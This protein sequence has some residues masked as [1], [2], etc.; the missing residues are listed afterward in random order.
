MPDVLTD[1]SRASL[2]R[3]VKANL[4]DFLKLMGRSPAA[5][6]VEDGPLISWH[7]ALPHPWF[8][9]VLASRTA[10]HDAECLIAGRLAY[11]QERGVASVSW[12]LEPH[13]EATDWQ[14]HLLRAG[15]RVDDHTPGMAVDLSKLRAPAQK[16]HG[17]EVVPVQ[18]DAALHAWLPPFLAG[19][20]LPTTLL[21]SLVELFTGLGFGLPLRQY[22]GY[23]DGEP[24]ATSSLYLGAGVAGI[25]NVATRAEARGGGI[26]TE[27]TVAPLRDAQEFG[28]K[29]GILQS[30][31][32]GFSLYLRLGFEQVCVMNHYIWQA[33]G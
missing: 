17:L 24:V 20:G 4:Y 15:F 28:Y 19:Y 12:W 21:E 10:P 5:A 6:V 25:Y 1:F 13:V 27:L 11:F 32:K 31:K 7:T 16:R 2:E 33:G 22:L 26:G 14:P 18:D 3:S 29:V 23:L 9:G 30:S 8:N